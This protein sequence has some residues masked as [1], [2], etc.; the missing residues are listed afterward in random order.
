MKRTAAA[1]AAARRCREEEAT[2]QRKNDRDAQMTTDRTAWEELLGE[3]WEQQMRRQPKEIRHLCS[4][5]IPPAMRRRAWI[6]LI[7]NRL[8][9]SRTLFSITRARAHALVVRQQHARG[10]QSELGRRSGSAAYVDNDS[11]EASGAM[12]TSQRTLGVPLS[13]SRP[14]DDG[15]GSGGGGGGAGGGGGGGGGNDGDDAPPATSCHPEA[16]E[17]ETGGSL[18]R[19]GS[20]EGSIALLALDLPRTFPQYAFFHD[21]STLREVLQ[22]FVTF[23]PDIGYV[24]GM[25]YLAAALLLYMDDAYEVFTCLANMLSTHLSGFYRFDMAKVWVLGRTL[26]AFLCMTIHWSHEYLCCCSIVYCRSMFTWKYSNFF[27]VPSF[28]CSSGISKTTA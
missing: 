4:R 24:Q 9:I 7:G 26:P 21:S 23:R 1:S 15:G 12:A 6:A 22:T 16:S 19:L 28:P 11:S 17:L 13:M 2:E 10:N 5:G 27:F 20:K 14:A 25:S 3:D 18:S 8:Q